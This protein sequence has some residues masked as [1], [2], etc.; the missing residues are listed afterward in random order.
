MVHPYD[1]PIVIESVAFTQR[2][3]R[4]GFSWLCINPDNSTVE[5][6]MRA[7][8]DSESWFDPL[9]PSTSPE[10][11]YSNTYFYQPQNP[12]TWYVWLCGDAN[13]D[14]ADDSLHMG[15][16]GTPLSTLRAT[17]IPQLGWSWRSEVFPSYSRPTLS[18]GFGPNTLNVWVREDGARFSRILL[19]RDPNYNPNGGIQCGAY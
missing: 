19:T 4:S 9:N 11:R 14:G 2:F 5:C 16:G 6:Y 15:A 17:V 3:Q 1:D 10:L 8:P 12:S 7:L 18:A 13:G